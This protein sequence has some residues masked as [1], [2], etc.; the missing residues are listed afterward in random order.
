[1]DV[2]A[3]KAQNASSLIVSAIL[4]CLDV[5]L[6]KHQDPIMMDANA[7]LI[8]NAHQSSVQTV[9][10]NLHVLLIM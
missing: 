4:A 8:Q 10:A 1:M 9:L 3:H 6:P 7:P 2:I 5:V